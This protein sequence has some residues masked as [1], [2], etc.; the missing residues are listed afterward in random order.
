ML[1]RHFSKQHAV[2]LI[3]LDN[4]WVG[5]I[6]I[7]FCQGNMWLSDSCWGFRHA[8][9]FVIWIYPHYQSL[10]IPVNH[11]FFFDCYDF[12]WIRNLAGEIAQEYTK[13]QVST[14]F[15]YFNSVRVIK[16]QFKDLECFFEFWISISFEVLQYA[17]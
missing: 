1:S 8:F 10:A 7:F 4:S 15:S 12:I 9:L 16:M 13:R 5:H 14:A 3:L 6:Y 17:C 11:F 2:L